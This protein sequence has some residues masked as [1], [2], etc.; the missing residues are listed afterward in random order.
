MGE[1]TLSWDDRE[2]FHV[3]WTSHPHPVFVMPDMLD[4]T[5]QS[6][7]FPM[8]PEFWRLIAETTEP[9]RTGLVFPVH[10]NWYRKLLDPASEDISK[11]LQRIGKLSKVVV[12]RTGNKTK[13]ASAH[14]L[15]RSFGL[16][17]ASK[18][19]QMQLGALMRHSS[20]QTT[21]TYYVGVNASSLLDALWEKA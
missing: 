19:H 1:L 15:R 8:A 21:A 20:P 14:D 4:K 5:G 6:R 9:E 2:A 17:W 13:Y 12:G 10:S 11:L 7:I 16:R 18:V 3:D